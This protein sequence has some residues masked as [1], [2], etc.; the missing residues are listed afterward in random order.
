VPRAGPAP[1]VF[2]GHNDTILSLVQTG[3]SFFRRSSEG[4]IDLP[5]AREGGLGGGFFAV[6]IH[7]P[8]AQ[9]AAKRSGAPDAA[10][11][12]A[13]P[14]MAQVTRSGGY[15]A[16]RTSLQAPLAGA[17]SKALADAAGGPIVRLPTIGGSA[18][19]YVF[20]DVLNVPTFGLS[21]VNFDNNQHGSNEN[22]RIKNLWEGIDSM[23]ALLTMR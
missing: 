12:A 14:L 22:V 17:I 6:Y 10:M 11:R 18:P 21:I 23:A 4:H 1:L 13:H 19:F 7:D 5:R 2:D 8:A 20:T 9:D 15:P 16:G 3:R